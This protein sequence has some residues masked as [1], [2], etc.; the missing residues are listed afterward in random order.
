[1]LLHTQHFLLIGLTVFILPYYC[2]TIW[3]G[4]D[5]LQIQ[6]QPKDNVLTVYTLRNVKVQFS[7]AGLLYHILPYVLFNNLYVEISDK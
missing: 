3:G 2:E 4:V 5:G 1:M 7:D 6:M